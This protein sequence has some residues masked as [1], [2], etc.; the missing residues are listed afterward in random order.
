MACPISELEA[1]GLYSNLVPPHLHYK[2]KWSNPAMV[3]EKCA[4]IA[5]NVKWPLDNCKSALA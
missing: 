1:D 5:A 3:W 4:Q 2:S